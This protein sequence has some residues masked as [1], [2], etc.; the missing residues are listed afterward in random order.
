MKRSASAHW[1]GN[2]K[3]GQGIVTTES[4][5]LRE[6]PYSFAKRFGEEQGTN[7]EEL[8][9]AAH[10]S[11]FAMAFSAEL[12]KQKFEASAIDVKATVSLENVDGGW[13][14]S[15]VHLDVSAEVPGA[16]E[17]Q[18]EE[19]AKSAKENCPISKLLKANI[20]MDLSYISESSMSL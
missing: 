3:R 20:T 5:T 8:I 7:P 4:E 17:K 18:V 9:A 6:A 19:A 13:S 1:S 16:T 15:A 10:S 2:L 14:V 11:C 12:E